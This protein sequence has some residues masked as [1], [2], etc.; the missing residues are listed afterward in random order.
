MYPYSIEEVAWAIARDR[1]E[2]ARQIRP[3]PEEKAD[4]SKSKI[5]RKPS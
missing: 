3:R 1:E 5:S 4:A 2:E